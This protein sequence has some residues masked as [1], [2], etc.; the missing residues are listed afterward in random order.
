ML[1]SIVGTIGLV[2]L[3]D[4]D[5][6]NASLTENCVKLVCDKNKIFPEFLYYFLSSSTGQSEIHAGRV[7]STQPKLPLYNI[8]KIKIPNL[9]LDEQKKAADILKSLDEKIEQN[10]KMNETLEQMGKTIFYHHII[11]NPK[12]EAWKNGNI[13]DVALVN[14]R[15]LSPKYSDFG[16]PVI[17]Q[18]CI[19]NGT[20]IEEAIQFHDNSQKNAPD[21]S[22]LR[23]NDVLINSM[24]VGTLGRVSQVYSISKE[25]IVHSCITILRADVNIIDP[26][27]LGYYIKY[28]EPEITQ[29]GAGTTGQTSLN[30]KLLGDI[31]ILLPD[32]E[33]QK[34]ISPIMNSVTAQMDANYKQIRTLITLRDILL[35]RLINE[36]VN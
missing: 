10:C 11:D 36:R 9:S 1:I 35:P 19:R 15:G 25:Y 34:L 26:I 30:N 13:S 3:V 2:A 4:E 6:N 22:Y 33:T 14:K 7:G 17:N 8:A 32:I 21:W 20:V 12:S 29:M 24:G 23:P 16:V 28:L 31:K 27:I 18:R 5:L